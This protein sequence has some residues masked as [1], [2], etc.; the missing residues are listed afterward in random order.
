[1]ED[2]KT[3]PVA[4]MSRM[5]PLVGREMIERLFI[6]VFGHLCLSASFHIWKVVVVS[7]KCRWRWR[8]LV[9]SR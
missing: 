6:E 1:M 2:N 5:A 8:C 3:E 7:E 4:L 9:G